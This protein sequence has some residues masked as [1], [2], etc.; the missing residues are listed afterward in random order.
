MVEEKGK[1]ALGWELTFYN[2]TLGVIEKT[3]ASEDDTIVNKEPEMTQEIAAENT[4]EVVPNV[5]PSI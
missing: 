5:Q 3:T 2:D 4:Q 1:I